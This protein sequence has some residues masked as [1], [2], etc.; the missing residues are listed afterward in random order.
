M[1]G[2]AII[3][4]DLREGMQYCKIIFPYKSFLCV[5]ADIFYS[6]ENEDVIIK[7]NTIVYVKGIIEEELNKSMK[8]Y[9]VITNSDRLSFIVNYDEEKI[10]IDTFLLNLCEKMHIR[11]R[12]EIGVSLY[13]ALGYS[14]NNRYVS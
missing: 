2:N 12:N 14:F 4:D 11:F 3:K 10:D 1:K 5:V 8:A 7:S 6:D 13:F 9:G